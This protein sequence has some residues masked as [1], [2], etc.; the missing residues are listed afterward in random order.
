M[1]YNARKKMHDTNLILKDRYD[2]VSS[3]DEKN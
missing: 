2:S 1:W 3:T